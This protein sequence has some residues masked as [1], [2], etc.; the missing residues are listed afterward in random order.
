MSAKRPSGKGTGDDA[1]G[2]ASKRTRAPKSGTGPP[3]R[4]TSILQFASVTPRRTEASKPPR[5]I[6]PF[7]LC[8]Q[9]PEQPPKAKPKQPDSET[10]RHFGYPNARL[11]TIMSHYALSH[12]PPQSFNS[13]LRATQT[14]GTA[15]MISTTENKLVRQRRK[16]AVLH[17]VH[18]LQLL[19]LRLALVPT[20]TPMRL[21]ASLQA[22]AV[23]R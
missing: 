18:Q 14:S 10:S 2:G 3:S 16:A 19:R 9:K 22:L 5:A 8:D 23:L 21:L 7:R 15:P 12:S 13:L 11:R 20:P 6:K 4:Q 17:R 1:A